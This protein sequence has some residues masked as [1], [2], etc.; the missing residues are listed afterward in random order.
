MGLTNTS[1]GKVLATDFEGERDIAVTLGW[2]QLGASA[3][4]VYPKYG[5]LPARVSLV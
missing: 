1:I 5:P 4:G 3:L 2:K